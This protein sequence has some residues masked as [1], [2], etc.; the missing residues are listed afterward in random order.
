MFHGILM[1]FGFGFLA[2]YGKVCGSDGESLF[3]TLFID[4]GSQS[5]ILMS[6]E[7]YDRVCVCTAHFSWYSIVY[8]YFSFNLCHTAAARRVG[9]QEFLLE[10]QS[11]ELKGVYLRKKKSF[12]ENTE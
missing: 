10:I 12:N 8:V 2:Q 11:V 4:F 1:R 9:G 7:H 5:N 6:Y 3:Y